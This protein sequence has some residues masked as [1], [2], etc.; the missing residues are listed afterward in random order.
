MCSHDFSLIFSIQLH[1]SVDW[2]CL[3][4]YRKSEHV[5]AITHYIVRKKCSLYWT[6]LCVS[7]FVRC[8]AVNLYKAAIISFY[9]TWNGSDIV[10]L[11]I[12]TVVLLQNCIDLRSSGL[13]FCIGMCALSS[14]VGDEVIRMQLEGVTEVREGEHRQPM[15]SSLIGTNPGVGFMS[16][17]CLACL[18]NIQN[19]L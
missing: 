11:H 9:A 12:I 10:Q 14:E 3:A 7:D 19:Y 15:T 4:H 6:F 8:D 17:E 2:V 18:I 16:V 5:A 1:G 13:G